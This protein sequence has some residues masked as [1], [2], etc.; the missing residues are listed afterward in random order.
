MSVTN[1]Y[2]Q[3]LV[4]VSGVDAVVIWTSGTGHSRIILSGFNGVF[5]SRTVVS[6]MYQLLADVEAMMPIGLDDTEEYQPES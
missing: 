5:S 3:S 4:T 1:I 2:Q 6:G